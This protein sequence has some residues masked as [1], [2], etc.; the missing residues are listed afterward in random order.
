MTDKW[1]DR[2]K[3]IPYESEMLFNEEDTPTAIRM[4]RIFEKR[5]ELYREYGQYDRITQDATS[6]VDACISAETE[7]QINGPNRGRT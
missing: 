4:R 7:Q 6:Y 2:Y 5:C 3:T 1:Y